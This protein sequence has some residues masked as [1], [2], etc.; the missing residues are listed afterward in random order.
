MS[1]MEIKRFVNSG[2]TPLN[3]YIDTEIKK[4]INSDEDKALDVI[5]RELCKKPFYFTGFKDKVENA[6]MS[7]S[8]LP[9]NFYQS[10]A[11]VYNNEIHILGAAGGMLY[12]YKWDGSSWTSVSTLPYSF[13]QGSAVVYNNEIH[14]LGSETRGYYT[15][16]YKWN[17]LTWTSVSTLP[18]N[19]YQSSAVVYNN[20]IHIL[21][22]GYDS[23]KYHYKWN[24]LTW[25]SVSTLP[26]SFFYGS[27]VVYN[28]EIHI[29]GG[30]GGRLYHYK[31]GGSS[32]VGI[33]TLP[34]SFYQGS[35]V[36]YN[37]EIHILGSETS[38]YYTAHYK[39]NGAAWVIVIA[40]PYSFY[41]GSA[42]VYNGE[43]H[44]LGGNGINTAHYKWDVV[45]YRRGILPCG[46]SI[47]ILDIPSQYIEPITNCTKDSDGS[48][49]VSSDGLVEFKVVGFDPS[50]YSIF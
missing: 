20:E 45:Y 46:V 15:A 16:H 3:N 37:G 27:S 25:T 13:Y 49:F 19:F 35:A 44:I 10:S 43:I 9:Y 29:L 36:V 47:H 12:H 41:Q 23:Q 38:G 26:Y 22:G 42:V 28:D 32:W 11:V 18:Y 21:G 40:I 7:T 48:I 8:T 24:G 39:W 2:N 30:A 33:S 34:Y 14:I 4:K 31:W 1:F 17:G 5:I 50:K 6:Q